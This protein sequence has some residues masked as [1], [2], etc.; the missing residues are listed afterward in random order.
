[1]KSSYL[2]FRAVPG[3]VRRVFVVKKAVEPSRLRDS[4]FTSA[5]G[6]AVAALLCGVLLVTSAVSR[7]LLIGNGVHLGLVAIWPA[8][9]GLRRSD[10]CPTRLR[11]VLGFCNTSKPSTKNNA[12][13]LLVVNIVKNFSFKCLILFTFRII[14]VCSYLINGCFCGIYFILKTQ[15]I[16]MNTWSKNKFFNGNILGYSYYKFLET[17]KIILIYIF[18]K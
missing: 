14:F 1:V 18:G 16:N 4:T 10:P 11:G 8:G 9:V 12:F 7:L 3:G 13:R 5:S 2:G 15:V 6:V 17:F